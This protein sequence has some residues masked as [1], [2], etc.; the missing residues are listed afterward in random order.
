VDVEMGKRA[1]MQTIGVLSGYPS[2]KSLPNTHP[3]FCFESIAQ[4]L[5]HFIP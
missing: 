1:G 4:L 5:T 2:S 3:D